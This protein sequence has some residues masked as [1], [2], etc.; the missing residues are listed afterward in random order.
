MWLDTFHSVTLMQ[1]LTLA[2]MMGLWLKLLPCAVVLH[3][4][5]STYG[6]AAAV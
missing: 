6:H 2:S 4:A 3:L 1:R 5:I